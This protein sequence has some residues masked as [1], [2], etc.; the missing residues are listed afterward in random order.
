M[1]F[2]DSSEAMDHDP[3]Q[4]LLEVLRQLRGPEGCA[5]DQ[6]QDLAS[7]SRFL[8]DEVFEY[9]DAAA[10]GDGGRAAEARSWRW[11]QAQPSGPRNWR[12]TSISCSMGRVSMD[13]PG[14]G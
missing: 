3:V 14:K 13:R 2:P 7:A 8:S 6:R 10:S 12:S 1:H 9:V 5:W 11:S 4:Q